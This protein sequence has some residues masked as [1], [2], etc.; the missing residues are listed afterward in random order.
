[1]NTA[2]NKTQER[3]KTLCERAF[4]ERD[5]KV[6]MR[7]VE[8]INQLLEEKDKPFKRTISGPNTQG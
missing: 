2:K 1:V 4:Q 3:W 6:L 7:L 5:P 8:E